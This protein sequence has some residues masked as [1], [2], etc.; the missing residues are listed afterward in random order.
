M[1][2]A[3]LEVVLDELTPEQRTAIDATKAQYMME[4]AV[5]FAGTIGRILETDYRGQKQAETPPPV[6]PTALVK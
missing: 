6:R 5:S 4:A 2:Q 1:P 3:I